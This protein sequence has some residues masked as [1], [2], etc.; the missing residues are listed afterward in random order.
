MKSLILRAKSL[1]SPGIL[2]VTEIAEQV[3]GRNDGKKNPKYVE[4]GRFRL[5]K[6]FDRWEE[7]RIESGYEEIVF[8]CFCF[9]G[10]FECLCLS[11]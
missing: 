3:L 11:R 4:N 5:G 6:E 2:S 8:G 1:I 7:G 10:V 9:G